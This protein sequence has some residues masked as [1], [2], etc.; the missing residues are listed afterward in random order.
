MIKIKRVYDEPEEDDG[1][2]IL[3]D[4][5]WP[6]GKKKEDLKIDLWLKDVAPSNELRKIYHGDPT[7]WDEFRR[8]YTKEL[9]CGRTFE[10]LVDMA[11]DHDITLL[12]ASRNRERNNAVVLKNLL[13]DKTQF[14][15]VCK[16]LRDLF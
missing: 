1:Q 3:V 14:Y 10:D 15:E 9:C 2:R 11:I 13:E 4:R 6:R 12:Y 8:A 7:K 16:S 5:L